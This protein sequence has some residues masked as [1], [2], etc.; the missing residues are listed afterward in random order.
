MA[1]TQEQIDWTMNLIKENK[2]LAIKLACSMTPDID[3]FFNSKITGDD[4]A[5]NTKILIDIKITKWPK[6]PPPF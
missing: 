4:V 1:L 6:T 3:D 2:I 5:M